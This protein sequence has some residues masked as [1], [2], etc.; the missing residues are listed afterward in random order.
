[1]E[2][3]EVALVLHQRGARQ[4]IEVLDAA[5]GEIGLHRLHQRQILA[6]RHRHA[7]GYSTRPTRNDRN[8]PRVGEDDVDG[9]ALQTTTRER[10]LW[11]LSI[12]LSMAL[13]LA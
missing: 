9:R 1:V 6:Q 7:G 8:G 13:L 4:I 10:A 11:V 3:V 12:V 2:L 5:G